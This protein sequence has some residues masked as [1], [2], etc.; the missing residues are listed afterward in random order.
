MN[1]EWIHVA[2]ETMPEE[3]TIVAVQMEDYPSFPITAYFVYS[4][5][6][7]DEWKDIDVSPIDR[8][9]MWCAL[10]VI[11]PV[12]RLKALAP[13]I[14]H[15]S[16]HK[17]PC[18]EFTP[19]TALA[20]IV[21]WAK[22]YPGA[23]L[24]APTPENNRVIIGHLISKLGHLHIKPEHYGAFTLS[25]VRLMDEHMFIVM[26]V[27][28]SANIGISGGAMSIVKYTPELEDRHATSYEIV[29]Y[30]VSMGWVYRLDILR[31]LQDKN[32]LSPGLN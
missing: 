26:S 25:G 11:K 10:P 17:Q 30:I 6:G 19:G 13:T 18:K 29:D 20:K 24:Y 3:G 27:P 31:I 2:P 1:S 9:L 4:D 32:I 23:R 28:E 8:P 15:T 12:P 5:E 7:V 21:N 22:L 16:L 14:V